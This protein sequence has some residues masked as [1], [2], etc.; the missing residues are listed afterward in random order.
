MLGWNVSHWWVHKADRKRC[1]K[2]A[3][4]HTL[5]EMENCV[6]KIQYLVYEQNSV[7]TLCQTYKWPISMET[8]FC[9]LQSLVVCVYRTYIIF[10][11]CECICSLNVVTRDRLNVRLWHLLF[12]PSIQYSAE[13]SDYVRN[14]SQNKNGVICLLKPK[15][16]SYLFQ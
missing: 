4:K 12:H 7:D 8:V 5:Y 10:S 2:H 15:L 16:V 3:S 6:Q 13:R 1:S 9:N 14:I 11:N